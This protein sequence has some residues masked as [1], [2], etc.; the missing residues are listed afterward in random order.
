M[1]RSILV[2]LLV[3]I[4]AISRASIYPTPSVCQLLFIIFAPRR[5]C[6]LAAAA[7]QGGGA[8]GQWVDK[9][10]AKLLKLQQL[11]CHWGEMLTESRLAVWCHYER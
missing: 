7:A 9:G 8:E 2:V 6:C 1:G 4:L 10:R 5:R 11:D 3:T